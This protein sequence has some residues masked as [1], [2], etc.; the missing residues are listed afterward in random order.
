MEDKAGP[1]L[2]LKDVAQLQSEI[3]LATKER[4]FLSD[5]NNV[6]RIDL[7]NKQT[8]VSILN[9]GNA[10][11]SKEISRMTAENA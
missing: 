6:K 4:D 5:A 3:R 11:V 10:A 7:K 9:Q 8:E 1:E 2:P